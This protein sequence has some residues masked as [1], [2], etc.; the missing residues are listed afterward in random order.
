[1]RLELEQ[2]SQI[3]T[4]VDPES[5]ALLDGF[6]QESMRLN[7]SDAISARRKAIA[8]FEFVDGLQ[9]PVGDWVCLPQQAMM[10]DARFYPQ[11]ELFNPARFLHPLSRGSSDTKTTRPRFTDVS[12]RWPVWGLGTAACPGRFYASLTLKLILIHVLKYYECELLDGQAPRS[13]CWRSSIVPRPSTII[14]FNKRRGEPGRSPLEG[15]QGEAL[16]RLGI[17]PPL[18]YLEYSYYGF[19]S[20]PTNSTSFLFLT[21]VKLKAPVRNF[22]MQGYLISLLL[23]LCQTPIA[24]SAAAPAPVSAGSSCCSNLQAVLPG[25]VHY[26]TDPSY[27]ASLA[28]YWS[29]QEQSLSPKCIVIPTSAQ[30]VS[31]ALRILSASGNCLFAIKSGG[32]M[33]QAGAANIQDGVTI[34]LSGLTHFSVSA[35]R[36]S[37]KLGPG[38]RWGQVYTKLAAYGLAV[39][40]GRSAD[41][42]VGGYLLGGGSS[43]FI[44]YGFGCDNVVSY[45]IVLASGLALNVTASSYADLFK[46]L[47]GGSSNFGIVTSFEA[48]PTV[49]QQ[50]KAYNEFAGDDNYNINAAVQMSISFSPKIGNVFVNQ[51]FYARPQMNPPALRPFTNIEPQLGNQT[52]LN[53]LAPFAVAS[54]AASPDGSRQ[55]T[56]ALSFENDLQT[57]HALYDA[58]DL[59]IASI[60]NVPGISWSVTLEPIPK[61]FLQASRAQGGN[62]LG[63]PQNPRGN[64]VILCDSSFTW[65]NSNDTTVVRAAGLKLLNDIIESAKQLKTYINWVD[66]NH[67]DFSQD[68]ISS[69]GSTN[70]AFLQTVSRKYDPTQVFQKF[71][72]GG[73]KL[74]S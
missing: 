57:L 2:A 69:Y 49:D 66:I 5:L 3:S 51:P 52:A 74:F 22:R 26:A 45:E 58:F 8:P 48:E 17:G 25:K 62:V 20:S 43:Y 41:V 18:E 16:M 9:V 11:P 37:T 30:D 38:L 72:P 28:T 13:R 59:S 46:A 23:S 7:T 44:G 42:G 54:G 60:A 47:K 24:A 71:V 73:F 19:R 33:A 67:A 12:S 65:I 4:P 55:M 50:L 34:D 68:P 10:R 53:M 40:G 56:W 21:L 35:D 6:V 31:A 61:V 27:N 32:H 1:M 64:A 63:L 70:K 39:P 36:K 29:Q 14:F 15:S